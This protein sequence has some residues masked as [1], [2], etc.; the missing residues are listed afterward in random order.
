MAMK[1]RVAKV[2]SGKHS[3]IPASKRRSKGRYIL[4]K[5]KILLAVQSGGR[6]EFPSCNKFLF[7]H[8]LTLKDGNFSEH[9]HIYPFSDRGP[10]SKDGKAPADLHSTSNLML[11]CAACHKEV[12][13]RPADYPREVLES[14]KREHEERVHHVTGLGPDLRTTVV[15]LKARIG[16]Q[17]VNIPA[18]HVY[19]AISPRYPIDKR[20]HIID[21]TGLGD[22]NTNAYYELAAKKIRQE[23]EALY[24][25]GMSVDSTRHIS[26]F[27]LAPIPVLVFLGT[28]LSNK[29][30]V[31]FFQRHRDQDHPWKW[32]AEGEPAQFTSRKL[33]GGSNPT[34]VALVLSLSG[35]IAREQLPMV[36]DGSYS[37]YEITLAG[38]SPGVDFLR[39]RRDLEAFRFTYRRFLAD[40]HAGHGGLEELH[41]FPAVPA[42]IAVCCGYDL[43]P[44]VHGALVVYDRDKRDG[45]FI[46]RIRVNDHETE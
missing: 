36:I 27:A 20:G 11:L 41:V 25:P 38:R 18:P 40:V 5:I 17:A 7:E 32:L 16:G 22:E 31:D 9:A 4:E 12:D 1:K 42:P 6:C 2:K 46:R 28:C 23:V 10:R 15:Q 29:I 35:V 3:K 13:S 43:L 21:L 26:L 44:K 30:A 8:P 33:Q 14:Y 39:Q 24:R 34:R 37:V 19:E 45:G